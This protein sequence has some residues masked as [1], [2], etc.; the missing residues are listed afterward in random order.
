MSKP[1]LKPC[2]FCG[3]KPKKYRVAVDKANWD[4]YEIPHKYKCPLYDSWL[5]YIDEP[6]DIRA[7]NRRVR[8]ENL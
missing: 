1:K 3:G 7:W 2:P 4:Q 6:K 8:C 5:D